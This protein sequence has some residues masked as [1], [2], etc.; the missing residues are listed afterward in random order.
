MGSTGPANSRPLDG[1]IAIVYGAGGWVGGAVA[2]AYWRA[3]ARVFLAGRGA[4]SLERTVRDRFDGAQIST[5]T[6]DACSGDQV[7]AHMRAI[8]GATGRLDIVFNAV[9]YGDVQG[10]SL[11]DLDLDTVSDRVRTT[12][13]AQY[14]VAQAAARHMIGQGEGL[15][16]TIVGHGQPWPG[17]GTTMVSWGLVEAMLRQWA[18]DLGPKGVRVAWLRT[19][20]FLESVMGNIDYGSS[21]A[22][23]ADVKAV[24]EG[25]REATLLKAIPSIE[26]A[27]HAAVYL[28]PARGTTACAINLTAGAASD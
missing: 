27:G 6:V 26:E 12:I 22:H 13:A 24:A 8:V 25:I 28:A 15:I 18:A 1:K 19:G 17:M 14:T 20:G 9:T 11:A 16:S 23:D 3:G 7:G 21:Y 5:D 2:H 10:V 4:P